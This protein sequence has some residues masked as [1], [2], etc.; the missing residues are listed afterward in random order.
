MNNKQIVSNVDTA[1]L[2]TGAI[3]GLAQIQQIIGIVLVSVQLTWIVGKCVYSA[4]K[5]YKEQKHDSIKN[6]VTQLVDGLRELQ[7]QV[8]GMKNG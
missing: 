3:I 8:N 7:E 2:T 4:V 6:D 5:H 1:M